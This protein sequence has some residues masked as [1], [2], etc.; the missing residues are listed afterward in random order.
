MLDNKKYYWLRWGG[1]VGGLKE[2]ED[3]MS[4]VPSFVK[5]RVQF[6]LLPSNSLTDPR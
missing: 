1:E 2:T 3:V 4:S 5:W 6:T